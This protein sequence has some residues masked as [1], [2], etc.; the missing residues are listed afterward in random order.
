MEYSCLK[1]LAAKHKSSIRKIMEKYNDHKGNWCIPYET[2]HGEKQ[3]YFAKYSDCKENP[4]STDK[5]SLI[6]M[7][8]Q[9]NTNSFDSKLKARVCELCGSTDS[10]KYEIHHVNKVKNLKGKK[11]WERIM[12]AK[13]RKT[14]VVCWDCHHNKIHG[15]S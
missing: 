3:L 5:I 6:P 10:E 1:T 7:F 8:C 2:K 14:M 15:K 4:V 9:V 12:I 13:K 11:H